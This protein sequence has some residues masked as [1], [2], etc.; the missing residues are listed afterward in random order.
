MV[1]ANVGTT[2]AS[3]KMSAG[4]DATAKHAAN[5]TADVLARFFSEHGWIH[6]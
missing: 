5:R 1:L 6:Y 2:I 3:E 4:I